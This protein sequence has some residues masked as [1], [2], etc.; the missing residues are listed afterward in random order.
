MMNGYV[1]IA[2][3]GR[4]RE[5]ATLLDFLAAQSAPPLLTV[6]VGA[7]PE[8]VD[9]LDTHPLVARGQLDI[10]CAPAAGLPLQ[11]NCGVTQLFSSPLFRSQSPGFVTFFDDD[12]RPGFD[13]LQQ[14][15]AL[16]ESD[17]EIVGLTGKVL[18]DGIKGAGLTEQEALLFLSGQ[19][20]ALPHWASG[21]TVRDLSS[22]YGCNMSFRTTVCERFRFDEA[23][24][25]YGWQEDRDF[26]GQAK[27]M[28][29]TVFA[30]LCRGVHL[31]IKKSRTPGFKFGYSQIANVL[32]LMKKGTMARTEGVKFL[33]K[34]LIANSLKSIRPHPIHDY[35]GR[36]RGNS[37]AISDLL[38]GNCHPMRVTEI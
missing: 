7:G 34:A 33:T 31:G 8:D 28:G 19:S 23:L 36:L 35:R 3:K 30:P 10:I 17:E 9:A 22:M 2:T 12:F 5:T 15:S 37:R 26:T 4:A 24:P 14:A 18:A 1:I 38:R 29:R 6:V 32:Y 13:W 16:F 27:T 11:R 25:A 21:D 20:S